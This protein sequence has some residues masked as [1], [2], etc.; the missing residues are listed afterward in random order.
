MKLVKETNSI[1]KQKC[2]LF[3]FNEPIIDPYELSEGLLSKG[4]SKYRYLN[5]KYIE[6][7]GK[8]CSYSDKIIKVGEPELFVPENEI[9]I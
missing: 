8:P 9:N 4:Y 5:K 2:E 7:D 1:L 3:D 6:W